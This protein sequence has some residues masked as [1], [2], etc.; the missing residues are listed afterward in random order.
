MP[1]MSHDVIGVMGW[2]GEGHGKFK[3]DNL[4]QIP[5]KP[6]SK[7]FIPIPYL[8]FSEIQSMKMLKT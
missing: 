8:I 2:A 5:H 4:W 1:M 7:Y 6:V 3:L